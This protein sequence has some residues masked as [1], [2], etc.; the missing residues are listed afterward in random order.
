M[1]LD[2]TVEDKVEQPIEVEPSFDIKQFRR[3]L[4]IGNFYD[5]NFNVFLVFPAIFLQFSL[6][7]LKLFIKKAA[8]STDVVHSFIESGGKP[9][10]IVEIIKSNEESSL[11][12]VSS[13]YS[14]LKSVVS[15][16]INDESQQT[17]STVQALKYLVNKNKMSIEK[18]LASSKPADKVLMLKILTIAT[19]LDSEIGR[20]IVKNIDV[21]GKSDDFSMFEDGKKKKT[22]FELSVRPAFTHFMLGFLFN[23]KDVVLRKKILQKHSLFE[24]FL[25]DLH[26]DSFET[27]KSVV[28]CLTKNVLIS[29]AF[30]KPEKLKIFTENAIKSILKLYE[31]K[32]DENEQQS[33]FN[34]AHQFLLLLLTSKK[35]GIVFK[36][37][38]E[39]KQNLRQLQVLNLFKNVWNAEFPSLLA[40]EIIK[41]CPDLM[42]NLLN[43][44]VM[45][46]QPRVTTNW[47]MCV[48]FTLELLKNLE[49]SSIFKS[50]SMLEAKKI[51]T[52]IIKLS[53]SQMILQNVNE[54]SLIQ[55]E[56][57]EIR[58][59][60]VHLLHL[61]MDRCCKYLEEV[62]KIE[63]LKDFEKH[64]IKFDIINHIFTFFPNVDIILNSLYR[65]ISL[66]ARIKSDDN[67]RLVKSQL[68]HTLEI[69]LLVIKN[70]PAIIEKVP[71]V[72]DFLEVL[73]PIYE[74]KLS[75]SENFDAS[76]DLEIEMKVVKIVLSLQPSILALESEKFQRIFQ[77]SFFAFLNQLTIGF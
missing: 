59:A 10:E 38:S 50:F 33:V 34:I 61:M 69:L 29:P 3:N 32:G 25:R 21:F 39:K 9:L 27:I 23:D 12:V 58:E 73:R 30:N 57:L 7:D 71:S 36:A 65:S 35:H 15:F 66:S 31:W 77:V 46:L 4:K 44:L 5:G 55:Q 16:I 53:I 1:F 37:L 22:S 49:P 70:F 20:E 72:I 52:N 63:T 19:S 68:K 40:I 24:F 26:L 42:Q 8:Q 2:E 54:R 76:E 18:M 13:L 74:F 45:G 41:S 51:S 6:K 11:E 28:T 56:S 43:R 14:M 17:H 64:R 48:N 60:S 62:K 75:S 67:E 47:F